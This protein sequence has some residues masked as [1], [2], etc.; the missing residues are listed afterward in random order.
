M[1]IDNIL[2]KLLKKPSFKKRKFDSATVFLK[3]FFKISFFDESL[4]NF[5]VVPAGISFT[6]GL[7]KTEVCGAVKYDVTCS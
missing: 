5:F 1:K 2:L 6:P 3:S 7:V 4:L